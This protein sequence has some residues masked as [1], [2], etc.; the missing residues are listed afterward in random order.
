MSSRRRCNAI[1]LIQVNNV[2]VEGVHNI[3]EADLT[4]FTSHF[5]VIDVDR[6]RLEEMDFRK[7][8]I[9][10]ATSLTCPFSLEEVKQAIWDCESF[11]SPGPD[12]ISFWFY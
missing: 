9:Q 7:L 6:P 3:R 1:Q 11:K 4:H 5:K 10:E 2:Q 8:F 12:E